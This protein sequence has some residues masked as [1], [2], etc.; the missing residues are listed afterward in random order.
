[1]LLS[2]FIKKTGLYVTAEDFEV[3]N[4]I[5]M[6]SE[7]FANNTEFCLWVKNMIKNI[8]NATTREIG[9]DDIMEMFKYI[10]GLV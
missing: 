1:M 6:T 3:F 2:E 4:S 10:E 8:K 7:N 9:W 5:Y